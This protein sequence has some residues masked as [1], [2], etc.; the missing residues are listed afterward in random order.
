[1][2]SSS[3]T[4]H[5]VIPALNEADH[6]GPTVDRVMLQDHPRHEVVVSLCACD[7]ETIAAARMSE[8]DYPG[9]VRLVIS[10]HGP[11]R[12]SYQV[13]AAIRTIPVSPEHVVDIF[14]AE[15]GIQPLLLRTMEAV[16]VET[17]CDVVQGGVQLMNLNRW[18]NVFAAMEYKGWFEGNM[19]R[20]A[21]TG[22]VLFG[23]NTI[24]MTTEHLARIGG[25]P[26]SLTED[27][28]GRHPVGHRGRQGRG[29]LQP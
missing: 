23:G 6:I 27:G 14:D 13:N 22:V 10:E 26:D 18:F 24:A 5:T 4:F 15:G 20:Q 17:G 25:I 1:M 11:H 12:K 3:K 19:A 8:V 28:V 2:A 9:R 7:Q 16:F 29:T 21:R